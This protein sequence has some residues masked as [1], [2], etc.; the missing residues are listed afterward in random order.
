M[1]FESRDAAYAAVCR[2]RD[3]LRQIVEKQ[4]RMNRTVALMALELDT[5]KAERD[6]LAD[7]NKRLNEAYEAMSRDLEL[8]SNRTAGM[9]RNKQ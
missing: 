1:C 2:E 5:V 4:A 7:D 3:E 9:M 6:A 8:M